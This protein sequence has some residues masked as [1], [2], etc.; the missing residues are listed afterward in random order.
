MQVQ[1]DRKFLIKILGK[2]VEFIDD[3]KTFGSY[4]NCCHLAYFRPQ[5][6]QDLILFFEFLKIYSSELQKKTNFLIFLKVLTINRLLYH[7]NTL[8]ARP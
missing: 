8:I 3:F 4:H 6:S 7:N 1:A 2:R 5:E